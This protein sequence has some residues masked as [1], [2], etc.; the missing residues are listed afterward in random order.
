MTLLGGQDTTYAFNYTPE[1]LEVFDN[2]HPN[3]EY[4]LNLI[5]LSLPHFVQR[6]CSL[7]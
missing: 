5:A 4:L 3:R 2:K 6:R 7:I 1:I